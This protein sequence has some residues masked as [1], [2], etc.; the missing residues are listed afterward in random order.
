[1]QANYKYILE[2]CNQLSPNLRILDYGCGSGDIVQKGLTNR[3][4]IVGVDVFYGGNSSKKTVLSRDLLNKHVF[5]LLDNFRIPFPDKSFDFVVSNQVMEHVENLTLTFREI[6]R[7]LKPNSLF[8][9]IF[10]DKRVFREGHCGIPFTHWFKKTSRL[11]YPYLRFMRFLGLGY[12]KNNKS[13]KQWSL[14]FINYLDKYTFYRSLNEIKNTFYSSGFSFKRIE[15]EYI[16]YRLRLVGI[17][18]PAIFTKNFIW[19]NFA[20]YICRMLGTL[21]ILAQKK[22]Q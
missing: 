7:I 6:N 20:N 17:K 8:L 14:D 19:Q 1:M 5:E 10:P 13:H 3:L 22:D 18:I 2:K 21:V 4:D 12:H 11:R 9:V 15:Y 16:E